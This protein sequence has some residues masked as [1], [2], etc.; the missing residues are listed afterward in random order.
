MIQPWKKIGSETLGHFRIFTLR[1]DKRVSPRTNQI[2]DFYVLESV[3]WVNVI[4]V[5]PDRQLVMIEQ[6]RHGAAPCPELAL[7]SEFETVVGI[8]AGQ[9]RPGRRRG[10]GI[11]RRRPDERPPRKKEHH[12]Q[13]AGSVSRQLRQRNEVRRRWR[14]ARRRRSM[15]RAD[16]PVGM[17][18]YPALGVMAPPLRS[19]AWDVLGA[20]D[21]G[22]CVAGC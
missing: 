16:R 3:N 19:G 12:P 2:H 20:R 22:V 14:A 6:F 9:E 5:T 4:A 13:H 7:A 1:S 17:R 11:E 10:L 8:H 18:S 15:R 21:V